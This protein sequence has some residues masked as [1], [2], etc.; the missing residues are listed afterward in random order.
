[1]KTNE[2]MELLLDEIRAENLDD[3]KSLP[4][5]LWAILNAGFAEEEGCVFLAAL[6]HKKEAA[7]MRRLDFPDRTG[8]ECFVNHLHLDDYLENGSLAPLV[9]LGR[10]LAF[11]QELKERLVGL[12]GG[13]HFR[14]I[15]ASDRESCT[16][17]FHTIR[18]D[19]EW[20]AKDLNGYKDEAVA[21][22]DT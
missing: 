7:S 20:S 8:Y 2:R 13:R 10:G 16:V 3:P 14:V 18:P 1:V 12:G 4:Q 5:K 22:L 6:K 9:M 17:R 19:E 21:V 15:V 11:A